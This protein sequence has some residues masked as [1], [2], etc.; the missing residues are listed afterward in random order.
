MIS[1]SLVTP[2]QTFHLTFSLY[3]LPFAFMNEGVLQPTPLSHPTA[4]ASPYSGASNLHRTKG[5]SC[6]WCQARPF[7]ATYGSG[8]IC[9]LLGWW[10]SL[11][12]DWVVWP[13]N[14]VLWGPELSLMVGSKHPHL[15][16][17]VAQGTTI[18]GSCQ[19][20]PLD[21]S[22]SVGVVWCLQTG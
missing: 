8:G 4:P 5:L 10:S 14:V 1:H 11:W 2:P 16:W 19:Q 3:P 9:T 6:H 12:E 15:H 13:A 18:P 22:N 20:A 7:S 17:P 21:N